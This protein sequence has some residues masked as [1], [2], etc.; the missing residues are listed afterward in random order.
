MVEDQGLLRRDSPGIQAWR[1][2][3]LQLS[4]VLL[5]LLLHAFWPL[6]NPLA[7]DFGA[8]AMALLF[9]AGFSI[10][11]LSYREFARARTTLRPDRGASALIRSGPFR[12]SRNPLYVAVVLLILGVGVWLNSL[13]IW[14]MVAPLVLVMNRAVILRE[15][16]YL[17]QEFGRD[18]VDYKKSVR[19]WL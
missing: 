16:S 2:A 7:A 1:P 9:G 5:G 15:E 8:L 12:Y 19:R 18:Y 14:L 3:A 6:E 4:S 17:E 13:W 11:A 10:I